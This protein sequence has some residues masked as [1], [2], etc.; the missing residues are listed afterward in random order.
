MLPH[1]GFLVHIAID[2]HGVAQC[3]MLLCVAICL[4][5]VARVAPIDQYTEYSVALCC[6]MFV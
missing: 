3:M 5:G 2:Q 6:Y 1:Y 4:Y